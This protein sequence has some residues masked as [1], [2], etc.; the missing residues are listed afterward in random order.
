MLESYRLRMAALGSY[1]GEARRRNSQKIMDAS[2]IRDP[3][4]KPVYVKWVDSGLPEIS[5][6]DVPVYAK[7]N[8]KSY[9][10]ITGDEI[11]Y[12]LQFRLEDMKENSNIRVG[13]YVKIKNELDEFDWWLI[14]HCD[15]RTQFR[16]FSIL[17]CTWTYKWVSHIGGERKIYECLGA[18][19]KQ[20]SYNSGVWL[21]YTTQTVEN[22]EVVWLPTNEDTKTILY[23]TK[24]LKS[25]PG[26]Y[27]PIRWTITKIEDTATDGISKFTLAQDMFDP[28]KDNEKLMI[29][30]YYDQ[31]SDSEDLDNEDIPSNNVQPQISDLEIIYSSQP[32]VRVG[33]GYKKF[34]LKEKVND[35]LI[36]IQSSIEWCVNGI[37]LEYTE[38][39]TQTV[40][41]GDGNGKLICLCEDN[42][43]KIKCINDYSLIGNKFNVSA[44]VGN[45]SNF[46]V[47][48]VASL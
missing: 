5:D 48:E 21:D 14:V 34:I 42:T 28:N 30:N 29:A 20:N 17:K 31:Y 32:I 16:Q 39:D 24:F 41:I 15:D 46:I 40:Q 36:D 27:P 38:S 13:S 10:N 23:D 37:V 35:E 44:K 1:E 26:R 7:Y 3:A 45:D 18:P 33:G 6:D 11:A 25:S 8:V 2:W 43:L 4:T 9:H 19:R 12:L 47:V 22:Q